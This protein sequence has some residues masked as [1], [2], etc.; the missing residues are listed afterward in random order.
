MPKIVSVY[1]M[2]Q[3]Y[4]KAKLA[5]LVEGDSKAPLSIA[6]PLKCRGGEGTTPFP[7]LLHFTFDP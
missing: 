6:T 4:N 7:G 5:T 1:G 3:T 2:L